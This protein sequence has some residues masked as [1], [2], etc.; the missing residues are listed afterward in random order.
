MDNINLRSVE[1]NNL[2]SV[3][4][5]SEFSKEKEDVFQDEKAIEIMDRLNRD[6]RKAKKN[7]KKVRDEM[8]KV[9]L[10]DEMLSEFIKKHPNVNVVNIGCGLDTRYYRVDSEELK[11]YNIDFEDIIKLRNETL[12][13]DR[14]PR[15]KNIALSCTDEKWAEEVDSKGSKTLFIIESLSMYLKNQ[16]VSKVLKIISNNFKNPEVYIHV[17]HMSKVK[18]AREKRN[19]YDEDFYIFGVKSGKDLEKISKLKYKRE[20]SVL[21]VYKKLGFS[22]F[23]KNKSKSEKVIVLES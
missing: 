17:V 5:R 18:N 6:F 7:K 14:N 8:T 20:K 9:V 12:E 23:L 16:E 4:I 1:E 2:I 11:W 13:E 22:T 10:L 3:A 19:S 21:D 15:I